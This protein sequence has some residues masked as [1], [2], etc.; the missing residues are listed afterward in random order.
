[1]KSVVI[2]AGFV[3]L[4]WGQDIYAQP[5]DIAWTQT[6]GGTSYD[7][8]NSVQQTTDGGYIVAGYTAP[9][10]RVAMMFIS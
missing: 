7:C 2:A 8:G 1:M 10:V 4:F 5:P 3:I 6:F 9:T